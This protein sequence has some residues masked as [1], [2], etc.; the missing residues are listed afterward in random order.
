M[1]SKRSRLGSASGD[2]RLNGQF[3]RRSHGVMSRLALLL[4][5]AVLGLPA[6]KSDG[7][8]DDTAGEPDAFVEV[9]G[10]LDAA[11]AG[12]DAESRLDATLHD[13]PSVQTDA[14][15]LDAPDVRADTSQPDPFD[16]TVADVQLDVDA[17]DGWELTIY[18][19]AVET[20]H[21]GTPTQVIGCKTTTCSNGSDDLGTYPSD[22]VQS[23][24]DQGTGRIATGTY[25]NMYLNWSID[26]GYWLDTAT[27]DARGVPLEP[28]V[29]AAA[30][31]SVAYD[32]KFRVMDCGVDL[33]TGEAIDSA[34]CDRL[35]NAT[36]VVRDR[37]TV[38]AVGAHF[39][40]YI[41][42]EDSP[43][44]GDSSVMISTKRTKVTFVQ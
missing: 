12:S 37:F 44:F 25:A 23:V 10:A 14:I 38:G 1:H 5:A 36:W 20:F 21:A 41:G 33:A 3:S 32:L 24:K 40:L 22:F 4:S 6:C 18:Y 11:D 9:G 34:V 7:R 35:Q 19:T 31:P 13:A 29:S 30:D 15:V 39:D 8:V 42:E 26:I 43:N 16:A 2:L 17:S 28:F 27:R